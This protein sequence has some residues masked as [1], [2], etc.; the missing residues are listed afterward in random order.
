MKRHRPGSSLLTGAHGDE[1]MHLDEEIAYSVLV[2]A[3]IYSEPD[4]VQK[5]QDNNPFNPTIGKQGLF[6]CQQHTLKNRGDRKACLEP[7][8][9][10]S[11][12]NLK[13]WAQLLECGFSQEPSEKQQDDEY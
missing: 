5:Q 2:G 13:H 7:D 6:K 4:R 12:A 10:P 9:H 8:N 1:I 11:H 3:K